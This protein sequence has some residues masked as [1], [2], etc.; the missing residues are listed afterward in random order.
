MESPN[1]KNRL[2]VL[3]VCDIILKSANHR[4]KFYLKM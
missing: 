3:K 4:S 1:R 2:N